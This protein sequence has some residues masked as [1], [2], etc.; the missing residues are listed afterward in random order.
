MFVFN[1]LLQF[2]IFHTFSFIHSLIQTLNTPSSVPRSAPLALSYGSVLL[3]M[4]GW[5]GYA[6]MANGWNG[7]TQ[8]P[9]KLKKMVKVVK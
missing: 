5:M 2:S 3:K 6:A 9:Q 8:Y 4:D 7:N 1:Y